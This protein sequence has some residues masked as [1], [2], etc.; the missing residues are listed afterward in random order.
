MNEPII[1][2][3]ELTRKQMLSANDRLHFQ[4][5]GKITR[6]LREIAHYKGMNVL[7]DYFG[8]PYTEDKPCEVR[9]IVYAPTKR[10]YDPP[11]WSLLN[12]RVNN[13]G[14]KIVTDLSVITSQTIK[15]KTLIQRPSEGLQN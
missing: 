8:L 13:S 2:K 7:K 15:H 14:W 10:K 9:V 5:K 6:F 1:L 4:Q 11:N 12:V 3:F